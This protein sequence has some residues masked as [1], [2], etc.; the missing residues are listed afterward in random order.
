MRREVTTSKISPVNSW[1]F[2]I[3]RVPDFLDRS[4]YC[5]KKQIISATLFQNLGQSQPSVTFFS[6]KLFLKK[7]DA[8]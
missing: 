2:N 6:H 4:K 1:F 3:Y 8:E 5:K 7:P